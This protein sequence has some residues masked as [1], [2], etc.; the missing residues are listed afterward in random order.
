MCGNRL[1]AIP[2]QETT[3]LRTGKDLNTSAIIHSPHQ[4]AVTDPQHTEWDLIFDLTGNDGQVSWQIANNDET[5]V[6]LCYDQ[7]SGE[8]TV[9]QHNQTSDRYATVG[10]V[11]QLRARIFVDTSSVEI[12]LNDGAATFTERYYNDQQPVMTTVAANRPT[13][14]AIKAYTLNMKG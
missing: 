14:T 10:H 12:F 13:A 4:L 9:H 6:S 11:H 2:A 5:L 7:S 8:V 3:R 1:G